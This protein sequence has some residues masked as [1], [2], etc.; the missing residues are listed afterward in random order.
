[1]KKKIIHV[2]VKR[3]GVGCYTILTKKHNHQ[4][5]HKKTVPVQVGEKTTSFKITHFDNVPVHIIV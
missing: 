5:N 2:G 4:R 3:T 1:M